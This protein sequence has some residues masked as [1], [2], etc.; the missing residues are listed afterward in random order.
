MP[1]AHPVDLHSISQASFSELDY[2][3]MGAAFAAHNEL[4]RLFEE[5]HY[6][7]H[8]EKCLLGLGHAVER[9][10]KISVTH[11]DFK[12]DYYVDLL[13]DQSVPYELKAVEELNPKHKAQALNYLYLCS[14]S[15]GKLINFRKP[16]V[17]SRFISTSLTHQERLNYV[18]DDTEWSESPRLPI[19]HILEE[20]LNEWGTCLSL[21][22]YRDALIHFCCMREILNN[23]LPIRTTSG[24]SGKMNLN[25]IDEDS[26]LY[27]TSTSKHLN[28]HKK[29][30]KKVL[31]MTGQQVAQWINFD[32]R[33]ISLSSIHAG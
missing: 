1:I 11:E 2:K 20:L 8:M 24:H 29:H 21:E 3:V 32:R 13:V 9:E 33:R 19:K 22:L 10:Y 4:G 23:P 5:N 25:R 27:V 31:G 16:S 28:D 12:K 15:H 14:L 17:E 6:A 18:I 30:L 7:Q 26:F